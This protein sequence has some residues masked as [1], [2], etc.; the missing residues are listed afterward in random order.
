MGQERAELQPDP[1]KARGPQASRPPAPPVPP[2][3]SEEEAINH[4][5]LFRKKRVLIPF[6]LLI[7]GMALG[8][9]YWYQNLKN[10]V[11]TDDAYLDAD[12]VS[13]SAKVLGR[14]V[15]LTVDEGSPVTRDDLLVRLDDTD[16]QAQVVQAKAGLDFAE[17]SLGLAKVTLDRATDDFARAEVQFK[18]SVITK[19]QYDHAQK[20]LEAARAEEAIALSRIGVAKAQLG[21][22]ETQLQNM[23]LSAPFD[24]TVAKR[25]LMEGDVVQPGQPIFTIYETRDIWVTANLEETKLG[26]IRLGDA[27]EVVIDAYPGR[28]FKGKVGLIGD[29]TAA[30][31]SLIPPNNASG[32]FTKITQRV[33]LRVYL[34]G[35]TPEVRREYSLR[36]GMSAEVKI[37]V[38]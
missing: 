13:I 30:Q 27:V 28:I 36:P 26:R 18:G 3:G 24:G 1:S 25:W 6:F 35:L 21:V 20:A 2:G 7:L 22:V 19:E 34:D 23:T 11:S 33:P 38:K 32:N 5:P 15:R 8:A 31:F 17:N 37:R 4:V 9:W 29:Y 14:I 10:Y 12:R 16:L